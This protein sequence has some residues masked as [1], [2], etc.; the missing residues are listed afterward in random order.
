MYHLPLE[1]TLKER[2][3]EAELET[4]DNQDHKV[5]LSIHPP[6][7]LPY[8]QHFLSKRKCNTV[9]MDMNIGM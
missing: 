7:A 5:C 3:D 8:L 4:G 9:H 1:K 6:Y 2:H